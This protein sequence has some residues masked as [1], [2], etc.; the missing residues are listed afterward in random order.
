[1]SRDK[2]ALPTW[3]NGNNA[4]KLVREGEVSMEQRVSTVL[5]AMRVLFLPVPDAAGPDS[6]RGYI[7]RNAIA[8]LSNFGREALD[9]PSARWLG[10]HCNRERVRRSGLWNSNHVDEQYE[11]GFLN[12]LER[13]IRVMEREQ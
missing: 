12:E 13:T 7:E 6:L 4:P 11:N 8:L 3:G 1:M 9:P 10:H 5:G 2:V